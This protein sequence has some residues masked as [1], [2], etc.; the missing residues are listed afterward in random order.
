LFFY[1][2]QVTNGSRRSEKFYSYY[3]SSSSVSSSYSSLSPKNPHGPNPNQDL[4]NLPD[5]TILVLYPS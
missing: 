1:R 2:P 3:S 5:E 4:K